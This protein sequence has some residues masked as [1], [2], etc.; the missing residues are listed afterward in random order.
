MTSRLL[1]S[2]R[3]V[4]EARLCRRRSGRCPPGVR[5]ECGYSCRIWGRYERQKNSSAF[6]QRAR[7]LFRLLPWIR[8]VPAHRTRK[9]LYSFHCPCPHGLRML[10]LIHIH[11]VLPLSYDIAHGV[12]TR[13]GFPSAHGAKR[14]IVPTTARPVTEMLTSAKVARK[15]RCP[16]PSHSFARSVFAKRVT[17]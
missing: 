8:F 4:A 16:R 9:R 13:P 14:R 6:T 11:R 15:G 5:Q 3:S 7:S 12:Y 17:N 10:S 1:L 2:V